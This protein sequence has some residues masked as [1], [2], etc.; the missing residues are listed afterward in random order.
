MNINQSSEVRPRLQLNQAQIGIIY[1]LIRVPFREF[2]ESVKVAFNEHDDYF[3]ALKDKRFK[4][5]HPQGINPP[6]HFEISCIRN[7]AAACLLNA[8]A[9]IEKASD[10]K[11]P[12]YY[13]PRPLESVGIQ[14]S[15]LEM[16]NEVYKRFKELKQ[17]VQSEVARA[18]GFKPKNFNKL[19]VMGEETLSTSQLRS[20]EEAFLKIIHSTAEI[21]IVRFQIPLAIEKTNQTV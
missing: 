17:R 5:R 1:Q 12:L 9:A 16:T 18:C 4:P 8:V 10:Y 7:I 14:K 6:T 20:A 11:L 13:Q 2:R 21:F 19:V 3:Y 15:D